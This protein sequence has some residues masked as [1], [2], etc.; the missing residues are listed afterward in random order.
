VEQF[1]FVRQSSDFAHLC[2]VPYGAPLAFAGVHMRRPFAFLSLSAIL[3]AAC[4]Q[5]PGESADEVAA[6]SSAIT[7]AMSLPFDV[8]PADLDDD[9]KS[10]LVALMGD[11]RWLLDRSSNGLGRWDTVTDK[12]YEQAPG[13]GLPGRAVIADYDGDGKSD[14]A[15][16]TTWGW[17]LIDFSRDGFHGW[18]VKQGGWGSATCIPVPG[19]YDGDGSADM[20]AKCESGHWLIDRAANGFNGLDL[21]I[22]GYGNNW[23]WPVPGDY[24]HDRKTDLASKDGNGHWYID[25]A[26]NGFGSWDRIL[27]G[28]GNSWFWP[29]PA[30][31][32]RDGAAD[33]ATK[34]GN[35]N[36]YIDYANNGFGSW[37]KIV[38]SYGPEAYRAIPANF[39]NQGD[40]DLAVVGE[41]GNVYVDL[42]SRGGLGGAEPWDL[43]APSIL[44]VTMPRQLTDALASSFNGALAV[45]NDLDLTGA[46]EVIVHSCQSIVGN[47]GKLD[48]G[49]MIFDRQ[50]AEHVLFDLQGNDIRIEGLRFRGP[51]DGNRSINLPPS[52]AMVVKSDY[53]S[54]SKGRRNVISGNEFFN[55]RGAGVEVA[56]L[57]GRPQV[58]DAGDILVSKN[59]FHHNSRDGAGYGVVISAGY[60]KIVGNVFNY[61]RHAIAGSGSE[62]SGYL[63][64]YNF[65]QQGGYTE[66]ACKWGVCANYWNQHFD[67]HGSGEHGYG[68]TAGEYMDIAFN[69]F[70]G[71]QTYGVPLPGLEETRPA[72]MLRGV[73]TLGADFHE[74][75]LVHDDY[76][77][78]ISLKGGG[79]GLRTRDNRYGED[80][81]NE[82]VAGDFDNDGVDDVFLGT[83]VAWFYSSGGKAPW[84]WINS[85]TQHASEVRLGQFDDDPRIDV[86]ATFGGKWQFSSGGTGPW[87]TLRSDSTPLA[88]LLFGDFDNNGKTDV[89]WATG[90]EWKVSWNARAAWAFIG[91][92]DHRARDLRVGKFDYL[93]GD[94][95]LAVLNG[96]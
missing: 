18:N 87:Q 8:E 92:P 84:V 7:S 19:D 10:D 96:Q 64:Y 36:W 60:A 71:E 22:P 77:E 35:G 17:W 89:I 25:F 62:G 23:F 58:A 66:D 28:Y 40:L 69:T 31:Y 14:L 21:D 6:T 11:G 20:A 41:C 88:D 56:V 27:D 43:R 79:G 44:N 29:V 81:T 83:G 33:I 61:N 52:T 93:P 86:F 63:A 12:I 51:A 85:A 32:D 48:E 76:D 78:A 80:Y 95:V 42:T 67:M 82:L 45:Q 34:D 2:D 57:D 72:L 39:D 74:N 4:G 46:Q 3:A 37:D 24:D 53:A 68:G 54:G 15:A 38:F 50:D 70:R 26:N 73:P 30:D 90:S 49:P 47:R 59:F 65:V 75:L 5:E 94:D 91:T 16:K 1:H 55:W 9:G 13:Q